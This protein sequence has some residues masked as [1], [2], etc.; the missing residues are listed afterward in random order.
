VILTWKT[1]SE[2]DNAGF[3]IYRADAEDGEY[4]KINASLIPAKGTTTEGANYQYIDKTPAT[5]KAYYYKLED[6][7]MSGS[8]TLHGPVSAGTWS[9]LSLIKR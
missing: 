6:V 1:E 7:D 5:G 9:L 8:A 2:I 4:V 3:N